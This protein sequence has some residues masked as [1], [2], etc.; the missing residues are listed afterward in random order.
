MNNINL[1]LVVAAHY[2]KEFRPTGN[3]LIQKYCETAAYIKYPFT[4]Y[5]Y[6][7]S[8]T[9]SLT[10]IDQSYVHLTRVE[11]QT[12]RGLS[13]VWNDGVKQAI[14]DGCN[15]IIISNDDIELND[16]VNIFIEQLINHKHNDVSI[17][18]PVS[19]GI[20]TGTQL[21]SGPIDRIIE[22]T[23]NNGNMI[24]GF[25]FG[26]T[27][28]FYFNYKMENENLIDEKNYP[29]GG[30]EEEFQRRIWTQGGRSFVIG[31]CHLY[32]H[33]IRGWKQHKQ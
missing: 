25:F 17:Y 28:N 14:Q 20:L 15:V 3:E 9:M 18:G 19:N 27:K 16:T 23:G 10:G 22:L 30:N 13:G 12:I 29:W 11:D 2:S 5:V 32:H 33:K 24:N 4:I 1:G 26:F 21:S 7:N 6:D 8:S 31:H